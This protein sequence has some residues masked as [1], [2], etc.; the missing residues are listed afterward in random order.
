[1]V[2]LAISVQHIE[3]KSEFVAGTELK[4]NLFCKID[5]VE[6]NPSELNA[7][8]NYRLSEFTYANLV[9]WSVLK[10]LARKGLCRL[11]LTKGNK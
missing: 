9:V 1:M 6:Y 3:I 11:M 7:R 10:N 2:V 5:N 4:K 8:Q